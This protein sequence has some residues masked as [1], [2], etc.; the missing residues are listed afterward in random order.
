MHKEAPKSTFT[1]VNDIQKNLTKPNLLPPRVSKSKPKPKSPPPPE[2]SG[3]RLSGWG[4][5]ICR[6]VRLGLLILAIVRAPGNG[7]D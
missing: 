5:E 4:W 7:Y 3:A 1:V 6:Y 2:A